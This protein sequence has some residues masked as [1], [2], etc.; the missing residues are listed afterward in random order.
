[1]KYTIF[2]SLIVCSFANAYEYQCSGL[3]NRAIVKIRAQEKP[4]SLGTLLGSEVTLREH[5]KE[6]DSLIKKMIGQRELSMILSIKSKS[7][8]LE[9]TVRS[10][11]GGVI[12]YTV[13]NENST[14]SLVCHG[15]R[16]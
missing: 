2:F 9:V 12:D 6:G 3:D 14:A 13:T 7:S 16:L 5:V 1:M 10:I 8:Q 4:Q 11:A 15:T